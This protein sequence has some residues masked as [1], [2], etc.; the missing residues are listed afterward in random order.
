[1]NEIQRLLEERNARETTPFVSIHQAN[2]TLLN[3][4]DSLQRK[5]QL[6]QRSR[7]AGNESNEL[8]E[9]LDKLQEELNS[10]IKA[11][12]ENRA[13]A[14]ETTTQLS[15]LKDAH[16]AQAQQVE[17]L[18]QEKE[19]LK[20]AIEHLTVELESARSDA[21]LAEQQYEGL[22]RAI[23]TLQEE[24]DELKKE[25]RHLETRLVA[26]KGK[27]S[28]E[29]NA[30][31]NLVDSLKKEVS[32]LREYKTQ[33]E[34][35][36]K[37]WFGSMTRSKTDAP[38]SPKKTDE[39]VRQWGTLGVVPPSSPKQTVTAH[40]AE[41]FCV[42]YDSGGSDLVAT[43]GSDSTVKVWDSSTGALRAT[44][45]GSTSH[46]LTTCDLRGNLAIGAG[47]DKTCR[48]WNV[49]TERMVSTLNPI[50]LLPPLIKMG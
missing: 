30:L 23:R 18:Q 15:N 26:D 46:A 47:S 48:V 5:C 17:N 8:K 9:K 35:R 40:S 28:D 6:L 45:R 1:M 34:K 3:Q 29:M 12:S 42:R 11:E 16:A 37:S 31:T 24:N 22:K 38:A 39:E 49:R 7:L 19:R 2:A 33:E 14:L 4:V 10:K 43:A 50:G 20:R 41:G 21:Q 44:L 32:M 27:I 36:N 13:V 25:N